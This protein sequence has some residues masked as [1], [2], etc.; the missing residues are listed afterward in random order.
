MR[1]KFIK[2]ADFL[3]FV[4]ELRDRSEGKIALLFDNATT[5]KTKLVKGFGAA[6]DIELVVLPV[7]TE[8][9]V[10]QVLLP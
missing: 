10:P 4:K 6:K 1:H 2:G 7:A 5:Y 9:V 3:E 8:G